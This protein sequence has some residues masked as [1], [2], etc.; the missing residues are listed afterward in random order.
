MQRPC[1]TVNH[2]IPITDDSRTG[3]RVVIGRRDN[4]SPMRTMR[5]MVG[6]RSPIYIHPLQAMV[7]EPVKPWLD[8]II[9]SGSLHV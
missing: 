4:R 1:V 2:M 7:S 6:L 5:A 8:P 3:Y 9:V